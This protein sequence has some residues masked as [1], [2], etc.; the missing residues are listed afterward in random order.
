MKVFISAG[1]RQVIFYV[2]EGDEKHSRKIWLANLSIDHEVREKAALKF[3]ENAKIVGLGRGSRG[4]IEIDI[5]VGDKLK[6][7]EEMLKVRLV[8]KEVK[9]VLRS[10]S[11][12]EMTLEEAYVQ[13]LPY[14]VARKLIKT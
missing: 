14:V 1:Y 12:G 7:L 2:Y 8:Y 3:M 13:L 9:G 5:E 4:D 11:E 10:Y 6:K